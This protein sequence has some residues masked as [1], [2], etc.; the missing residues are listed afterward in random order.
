MPDI[1]EAAAQ[2]DVESAILD[3]EAVALDKHGV[4][5]F[6]DLRR[7]FRKG[8]NT[9]LRISHSTSSTWTDT[10]CAACHSRS[11]KKFS[12]VC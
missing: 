12:K 6:A 11:E 7:H 10:I 2:L 1:A 3:G 8:G 9:T 5:N 4:S